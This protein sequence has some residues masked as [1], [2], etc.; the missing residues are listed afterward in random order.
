MT[1]RAEADNPDSRRHPYGPRPLAALLPPIVRPVLKKRAPATAALIA[2]WE[3]IVGPE[4]SRATTPRKLFAGTL[5]IG[6]AGPVALELQHL[7]G[8]LMERINRH[9]G[10]LTVTSLR[11]HQEATRRISIPAS[12]PPKPRDQKVARARVA[13]IA[14]PALREALELLGSHL[15]FSEDTRTA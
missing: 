3:A 11:F 10:Q 2:D 1:T 9:L 12:K 13:D 6:C 15:D 8:A 5:T 14:D 4:L 7:S